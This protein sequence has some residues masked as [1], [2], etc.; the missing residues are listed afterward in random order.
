MCHLRIRMTCTE[1]DNSEEQAKIFCRKS[2]S[3]RRKII[4]KKKSKKK[5]ANISACSCCKLEI[6]FHEMLP[7]T[8]LPTEA[9]LCS[10]SMRIYHTKPRDIQCY[11]KTRTRTEN[12]LF[13]VNLNMFSFFF[14]L[15]VFFFFC[16]K[17]KLYF[18]SFHVFQF[19]FF[20]SHF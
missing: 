10:V 20:T 1:T 2:V 6:V 5:Q 17:Q 7:H 11:D 14:N 3:I 15:V 19:H 16:L 13:R 8:N 18:A 9:L 4:E 12:F